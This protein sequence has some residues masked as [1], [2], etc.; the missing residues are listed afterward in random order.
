MKW[1]IPPE[2]SISQLV[3]IRDG[4][5]SGEIS[6]SFSDEVQ[7]TEEIEKWRLIVTGQLIAEYDRQ[8]R[9]RAS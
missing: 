2:L 6:L 3:E 4:L 7:V 9:L 5:K 1:D 8:I